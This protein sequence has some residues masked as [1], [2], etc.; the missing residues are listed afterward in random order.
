MDDAVRGNWP[1]T[2]P[3]WRA[4]LNLVAVEKTAMSGLVLCRAHTFAGLSGTWQ[5]IRSARSPVPHS[6]RR[7]YDSYALTPI[8]DSPLGGQLNPSRLPTATRPIF[9]RGKVRSKPRGPPSRQLRGNLMAAA[10]AL[11]LVSGR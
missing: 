3:L 10:P 6:T 2:T 1:A 4:D 11:R 7:M 5:S 8:D 9:G